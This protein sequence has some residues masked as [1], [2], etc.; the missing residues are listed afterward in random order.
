MVV[1]QKST[2]SLA[3][4]VQLDVLRAEF[5]HAADF[6]FGSKADLTAAKPDFRFNPELGL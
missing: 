5:R 1:I 4:P 2:Q 6:R 3:V